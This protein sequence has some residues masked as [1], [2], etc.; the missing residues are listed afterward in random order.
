MIYLLAIIV[1]LGVL[2]FVHELGHFLGLGANCAR[3]MVPAPGS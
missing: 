2:V 3:A 1:A